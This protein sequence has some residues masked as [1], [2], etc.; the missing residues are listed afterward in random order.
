MR[1][2]DVNVFVYAFR[3]DLPRHGEY[4]P[5]V[6]SRLAGAEPVGVSEFVL[7]GFLRVVTNHRVFREPTTPEDALA[8]C[9]AVRHAPAAVPV[10][11][12][13]RHW[14]VFEELCR[15]V[16]AKGNTVAD[17]YHAALAIEHGATWVSADRDFAKFPGLS[18]ELPPVPA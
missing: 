13:D 11:A 4:R 9:A 2:F 10:R 12:G 15:T 8:F 17:V 6:E 1:I 7:S 18:W 3:E 5:W 14:M 16:A